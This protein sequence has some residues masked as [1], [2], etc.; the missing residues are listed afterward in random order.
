MTLVVLVGH[1]DIGNIPTPAIEAIV[2][3][4]VGGVAVL[5]AVIIFAIYLIRRASR[6]NNPTEPS[7]L[8]LANHTHLRSQPD[9]TISNNNNNNNNNMMSMPN[10]STPTGYASLSSSPMRPSSSTI[11]THASSSIRSSPFSSTRGNTVAPSMRQQSPPSVSMHRDETAVEPAVLGQIHGERGSA[12]TLHSATSGSSDSAP[13]VGGSNK[14]RSNKARSNVVN[15]AA[16]ESLAPS[17]T[18]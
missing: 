15:S 2:G 16:S 18:V 12:D 17:W 4:V 5:L 9:D 3:G 10:M 13:R 11:R 6:L 1:S 8:F 7:P 14:A